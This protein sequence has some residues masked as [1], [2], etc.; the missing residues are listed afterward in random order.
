MCCRCSC[1]VP[2]VATVAV[3]FYPCSCVCCAA[4]VAMMS[5]KLWAFAL[6]Q[7]ATLNCGYCT[8]VDAALVPVS[9]TYFVIYSG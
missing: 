9:M 6:A 3:L 8:N 2:K 1:D 4:T 7:A 5:P